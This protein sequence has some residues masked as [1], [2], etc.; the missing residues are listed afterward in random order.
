MASMNLHRLAPGVIKGGQ[1]APSIDLY[2][3]DE[4]VILAV[5]LPGIDPARLRV[6]AND[7][8]VRI[9][10]GCRPHTIQGRYLQMERCHDEF[11]RPLMLPVA[12]D[13]HRAVAQYEQGVLTVTLP[14]IQE[15]RNTTIDIPVSGT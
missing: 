10:G 12:V 6:S 8:Q 1:A 15:R 5:D 3:T 14:K 2:E 4:A 13:P 11:A 9:E 7:R